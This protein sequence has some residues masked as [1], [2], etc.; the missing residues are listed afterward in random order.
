MEYNDYIELLNHTYSNLK[1]EADYYKCVFVYLI[2][3]LA[4][5]NENAE[6]ILE[7]ISEYINDLI[8]DSSK[9]EK[10]VFL[11]KKRS[12]EIVHMYGPIFFEGNPEYQL[13]ENMLKRIS[14]SS[15][16]RAMDAYS[17][18]F[19]YQRLITNRILLEQKYNMPKRKKYL[20]EREYNSYFQV[21]KNK[22]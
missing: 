18:I 20:T 5:A 4:I 19:T 1:N 8:E 10:L 11:I 13:Y 16:K 2:F 14:N 9:E 3:M 21:L 15:K 7:I 22:D 17:V 12:E 6:D